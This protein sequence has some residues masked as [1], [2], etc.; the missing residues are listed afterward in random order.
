MRKLLLSLAGVFFAFLIGHAQF[1]KKIEVTQGRLE[2]ITPVIKDLP[3]MQ[4][5]PPATFRK[6]MSEKNTEVEDVRKVYSNG[7]I[8]GGDPV[9]QR[10]NLNGAARENEPSGMDGSTIIKSWD[11]LNAPGVSPT[12]PCL[13]AGP[14]H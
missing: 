1:I 7:E 9:L 6:L 4:V 8:P 11:G 3:D 5:P 12:D 14:N 2:K 10:R 13:A